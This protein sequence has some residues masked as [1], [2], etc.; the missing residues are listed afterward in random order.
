MELAMER[1]LALQT[2]EA[3]SDVPEPAASTCSGGIFGCTQIIII[4]G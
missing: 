1:V 2:L 4:I 3:S